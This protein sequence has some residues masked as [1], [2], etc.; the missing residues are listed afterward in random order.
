MNY[1]TREVQNVSKQD[2]A[3]EFEKYLLR[4]K[5]ENKNFFFELNLEVDHS[6]KNPKLLPQLHPN[7]HGSE[8]RFKPVDRIAN[9]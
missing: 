1:I 8:N 3:K 2:D 9:R 7:H 4:M 5:E 6:I